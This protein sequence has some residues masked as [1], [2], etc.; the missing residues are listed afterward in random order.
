MSGP[1]AKRERVW[2]VSAMGVASAR[3]AVETAP[4]EDP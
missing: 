3:K 1:Y 4:Q 2:A